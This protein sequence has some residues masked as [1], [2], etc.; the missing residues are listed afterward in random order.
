MCIDGRFA[1]DTQAAQRA[2]DIRAQIA[3]ETVVLLVA[4]VILDF[5][6]VGVIVGIGDACHAETPAAAGQRDVPAGD[7]FVHGMPL[8]PFRFRNVQAIRGN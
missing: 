4:V 8:R 3:P 5:A 6:S 7:V 1:E 2:I